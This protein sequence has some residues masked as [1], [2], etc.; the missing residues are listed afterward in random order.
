MV[1]SRRRLL[2]GGLGLAGAGLL[3][4]CASASSGH[5][6]TPRSYPTP[7]LTPAPGRRVVEASLR[8]RPVTLDL[9]GVAARTWGYDDA[10]GTVLRATA[11]DVLAVR[12]D[13]DLPASTS[14]HWHGIRLHHA[15]DGVPGV[16][17]PPIE[18]GHGFDYRFLAPDPG[19]YFFHP[20]SGIQL[21]RALYAPLIIDDPAEPG[22]YDDEWVV[23]LDDWT[24]GVGRDPDEILAG[25]LAQ[26][27]PVS[28]GMGHGGGM[29]RGM[30]PGMGSPLGDAGDVDHPY[31]L[32]NGRI[33][34]APVTLRGRPGR[35]VRLRIINAA[36]DTIYQVALGGHVLAVTH[37]DGFAVVPRDARS[38]YL[39][40]GER[41][42]ALVTLADGAFPLVGRPLGK[43][44]V[45][46]AVVRTAAGAAAPSPAARV[47]ELDADAL[48]T[49]DLRAAESARLP[50]RRVDDVHQV[51]LNGQ[52]EPYGWGLNGRK[53][54]DHEPIDVTAGRRVRVRLTN[55]TMMA[56]PM[57]LHGHTWSLPGSAGLRKD[58]V[59]L[60]PMQSVDLD[61]DTDN[62][63]EW[64]LH[65]HNLYHAEVGMMTTLRYLP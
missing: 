54:G 27:G 61:L 59:L 26:D 65:C 35:R 40:M 49:T 30:G 8:P 48:L 57:H 32:V 58:T 53:F 11:G 64:M 63:G 39:G 24:D 47:P 9:G 3:P 1:L 28:R 36:A 43:Q 38:L 33:P 19:T 37:T 55:L 10:W 20:H 34:D 60:S 22:G 45:A 41:V 13:N 52:M 5:G 51:E 56:H 14:V 7:V 4:G 2:L 62:P 42:D 44:G 31:H 29:G 16:T 18:P 23:V 6:G 46:F 50:Q 25:F 17:Q 15:A 12:V 21:D